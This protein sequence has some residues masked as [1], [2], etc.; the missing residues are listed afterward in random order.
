MNITLST[1]FAEFLQQAEIFFQ[2]SVYSTE[3]FA[4]LGI[5]I[6]DCFSTDGGIKQFLCIYINLICLQVHDL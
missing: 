5:Y 2:L 6:S 1:P 3:V 4:M